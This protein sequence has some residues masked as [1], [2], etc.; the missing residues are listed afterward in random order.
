MS[1]AYDERFQLVMQVEAAGLVYVLINGN[2]FKV[3]YKVGCTLQVVLAE[4]KRFFC[5]F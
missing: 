1:E 3:F 5:G 4:F 2:L